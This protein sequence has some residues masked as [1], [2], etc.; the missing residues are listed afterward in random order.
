MSSTQLVSVRFDALNL[1]DSAPDPRY[2]VEVYFNGVK[3][4]TEVLIR[5]A[6]LGQTITTAPFTL[7][8]VNA[9][10]GVGFDNIISLRGISHSS[11]GGGSW[12]GIDYV[13]LNPAEPGAVIP[14]PVLPW[15]VGMDDD[16]WPPG[17]GGG[18]NATFVLPDGVPNPLPGSPINEEFDMAADD[19]YYLAGSYTTVIA[20]NGT[21]TRRRCCSRQRGGCQWWVLRR[22]Q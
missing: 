1:D 19:D 5:T 9:G 8:S 20:G 7:R 10:L 22:R 11:D 13:E 16:A 4:Q 17:D 15:S 14:P 18:P 2:G 3:V 12:M 21:Y 6:Q